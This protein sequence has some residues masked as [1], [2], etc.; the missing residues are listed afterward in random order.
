MFF[1]SSPPSSVFYL[2]VLRN[3]NYFETYIVV[4]TLRV[5]GKFGLDEIQVGVAIFF[6]SSWTKGRIV[7]TIDPKQKRKK[8][9]DSI[10]KI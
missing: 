3:I 7:P 1:Y 8:K 4:F 9:S 10:E 6:G 2:V 5:I